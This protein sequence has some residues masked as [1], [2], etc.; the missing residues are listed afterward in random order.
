[1]ERPS[2]QRRRLERRRLFDRRSPVARRAGADRRRGERRRTSRAVVHDRRSPLERRRA[3]RRGVVDRRFITTRRRGLRRRDTPTP[4]TTEELVGV[5]AAFS[6][7]GPTTC[8]HCGGP[9]MLGRPRRRGA[10]VVR[11]VRCT[12]CGKTAVITNSRAARVLVIEQKDVIRDTL[13]TILAGAG[14]DVV[15][16]ADAG[17]GLAAYELAPPDLVFID[18]LGSGRMDAPEFVRRLR[19]VFPD[20]RVVA[21]ASRPSYGV[22]DPLAVARQLGAAG[23]IRM[24]FSRDEVLRVVDQTRH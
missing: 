16:A 4:F 5:R 6:H 21:M 22:A 15:E 18:V 8:P 14:H 23:T 7:P 19:Q 2:E 20:A 3:I 12:G 17:V 11:Q 9:F 10:D 24:P 1:V 13:R